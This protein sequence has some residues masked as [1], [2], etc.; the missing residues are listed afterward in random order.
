MP[1][2][3]FWILIAFCLLGQVLVTKKIRVGFMLWIIADGI[4]AIFNFSQYKLPGA[5]EQGCLWTMYFIISLWGWL[6]FTRKFKV[7]KYCDGHGYR[8]WSTP[9]FHKTKCVICDGKGKVKINEKD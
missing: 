7:C 3:M 4:W 8:L 2:L 9:R 5:I 6:I 1:K